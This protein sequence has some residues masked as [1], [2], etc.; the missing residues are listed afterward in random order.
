MVFAS[1]E[2]VRSYYSKFAQR[3]VGVKIVLRHLKIY[4][5]TKYF[6]T[7]YFYFIYYFFIKLWGDDIIVSPEILRHLRLY[8]MTNMV[9]STI[10]FV[11]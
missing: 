1:P 6:V 5:V 11:T 10:V 8:G 7:D 3:E 9:S 4:V 2:E